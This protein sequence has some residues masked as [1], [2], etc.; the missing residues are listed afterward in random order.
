MQLRTRSIRTDSTY[1]S[2]QYTPALAAAC[3][4]PSCPGS[5]WSSCGGE[6]GCRPCPGETAARIHTR[7]S[8]ACRRPRKGDSGSCSGSVGVCEGAARSPA[9]EPSSRCP[10][11]AEAC[12]H[13]TAG[14]RALAAS[15]AMSS[16]SGWFQH[17]ARFY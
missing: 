17:S 15:K 10:S 2:Y 4:P 5:R 9:W 8:P 3:S 11:A 6:R 7:T 14:L 13:K 1:N 16:S 12:Q